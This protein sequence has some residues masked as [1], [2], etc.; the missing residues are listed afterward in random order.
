MASGRGNGKSYMLVQY[1]VA[2]YRRGAESTVT[3]PDD[4][5]N[6]NVF[7]FSVKA[8]VWKT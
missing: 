5:N 6:D 8:K 4:D 7:I 1:T 3:N 2:S